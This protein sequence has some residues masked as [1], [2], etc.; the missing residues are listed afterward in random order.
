MKIT[1]EGFYTLMVGKQAGYMVTSFI[2]MFKVIRQQED[3]QT[4]TQTTTVTFTTTYTIITI[5]S[6]R[7]TVTS[8]DIYTPKRGLLG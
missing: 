1:K 4:I 5:T 7:T 3:T 8:M 2:L 6:Y